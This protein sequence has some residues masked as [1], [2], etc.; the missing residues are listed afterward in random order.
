MATR[1]TLSNTEKKVSTHKR[2]TSGL[3][4]FK[5]GYDPRRNTKGRPKSFDELRELF[6][7]IAHDEVEVDGKKMTRAE[8]IGI[9][10][11]TDKDKM[12]KF[13]EFAYGKVP[14]SQIV[15]ITS[16]GKP[17]GWKDFINGDDSD[18]NTEADSK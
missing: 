17:I 1:K 13:L 14:L 3:I 6:Q 15:D 12:E 4:P 18:T 5:S 16:G 8:A 11:T 2:N 10:M 9:L 7:K